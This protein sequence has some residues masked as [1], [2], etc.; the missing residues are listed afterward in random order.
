MFAIRYWSVLIVIAAAAVGFFV[1]ASTGHGGRFDFKLGLDLSGGS[2]LVYTVDATK[3]AAADLPDALV[4]LQQ[5]IERRVNAFG[6]G[7]PVVQLEQG[8]VLGGG[9]HRLV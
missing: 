7:E 4:A 9:Q 5:V 8:G 1:Y 2:H 6:V 3:V